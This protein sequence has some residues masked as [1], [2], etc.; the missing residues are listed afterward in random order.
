MM[1]M[2]GQ[3]LLVSLMAVML[4]MSFG[5]ISKKRFRANTESTDGRIS[6]V[7][8]GLEANERRIKDLREETDEKIGRLEADTDRALR[9]GEQAQDTAERAARGRLL[10]TVNL[11]ND[12]VKFDLERAVLSPEGE[13]ALDEL[14]AKVKGYGKAVYLEIE[15]HTDSTGEESYNKML[16]EK[17][18]K[19]VRDY[20]SEAGGIPL[21][22][23]NTI[24]F[25]EGK[26]IADNGTREGRAQNRRVVIH[27]LE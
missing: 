11:S 9:A 24:S 5:C 8:S 21:H 19:S 22:A 23:M 7:E 13:A 4:V 6:S 2:R 18:A 14:V 10:W 15:G 17:R 16:G 1:R 3:A 27:V 25:G 26:P 12:Q 20:L